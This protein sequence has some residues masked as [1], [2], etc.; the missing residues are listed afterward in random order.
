MNDFKHTRP[1]RGAVSKIALCALLLTSFAACSKPDKP[2]ELLEI[3]ALWQDPATRQ[4][5]DIPGAKTYYEESR[6]FR[7]DAQDYY[8]EGD[9]EVA[10]EYAIYS[11]LR[12]R[13]ALAIAKEFKEQERLAAANKRVAEINPEVV[14]ANQERNKLNDEVGALERELAV[15]KRKKADEDRRKAALAKSGSGSSGSDDAAKT[16]MVDD[17]IRQVEA[18]RNSAMAVNAQENAAATY[19]RANNQLNS[20]KM[21]RASSPINHDMIMNTAD[22]AI[23]DFQRAAQE[24]QPGYKEQVAKQD[25][26]ARRAAL[27]TTAQAIFGAENVQQEGIGIRIVAPGSFPTGSS[28]MTST[29]S[30]YLEALVK[31]AKDYDEFSITIEGF[32]SRGDATENLSLSQLRARA[33]ED[34][35]VKAGIKKSRIE[36]KGQGQ[37]RIRYPDNRSRNERVEVIFRR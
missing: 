26:A 8:D 9:V 32:T 3:E 24:A 28:S 35:M 27:M 21:M 7:Y 23:R 33:A 12:Y 29:G 18:A 16:K 17:K 15:A 37:E 22:A 1:W 20:I 30:R 10:R 2:K 36:T 11:K 5:K 14:A 31:L 25:P 13:A 19:N 4:V 6:K 34:A